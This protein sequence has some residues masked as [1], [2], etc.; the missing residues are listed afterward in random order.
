M[1]NKKPLV[2]IICLSYNHEKYVNQTLMSILNQETDFFYEIIVHD[3]ASIDNTQSILKSYKEKYPGIIRLILQKEN[4][5]SKGKDIINEFLVP[6]AQGKYV[7]ICECDDFWCDNRKLQKQ[8]DI[9]ER[10][11]DCSASISRVDCVNEQ[12]NQIDDFFPRSR[13]LKQGKIKSD[14]FIPLVL[15]TESLSLLQFQLSG[16]MVRKSVLNQYSKENPLYK[17]IMDVG[18]IPLFLYCGLSGNVYYL[19]DTMSCYRIGAIGSWNQ[20][21]SGTQKKNYT[22]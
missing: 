6:M 1:M 19:N 20:N 17:Q 4:Q 7:A 8:V 11:T 13:F 10:E 14:T 16:L 18:D 2:S 21:H 9:L 15:N 5:Y 3:D 12:G 22:S